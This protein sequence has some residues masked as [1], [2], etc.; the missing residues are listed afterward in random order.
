M[1]K[2]HEGLKGKPRIM[3][4]ERKNPKMSYRSG[5]RPMANH[6]LLPVAAVGRSIVSAA[7]DK[8]NL[9]P[10]LQ[11]FTNWNINN[12]KNMIML[13]T[14]KAFWKA[15]GKGGDKKNP[16]KVLPFACHSW[17]HMAYNAEVAE[18]LEEVWNKVKITITAHKFDASS[19]VRSIT[20]KQTKWRGHV[21]RPS[22]TLQNWR[23]MVDEVADAHNHFTMVDVA[24][25]PY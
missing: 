13:P 12:G 20:Q 1:A 18:D 14:K 24:E 22:A 5:K 19:V 10:A 17:A 2:K 9:V 8:E 11:Y 6:H 7:D 4:W 25:S 23:K 21:T 3:F 16:I 15:F